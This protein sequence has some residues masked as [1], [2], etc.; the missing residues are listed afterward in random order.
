MKSKTQKIIFEFS[1][2]DN[3]IYWNLIV[4]LT[5]HD[6]TTFHTVE[7]DVNKSWEN[8][9]FKGRIRGRD[10]FLKRGMKGKK[11]PAMR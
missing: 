5:M 1:F 7:T 11:S 8:T 3:I 6:V 10:F 2:S 9:T 4:K